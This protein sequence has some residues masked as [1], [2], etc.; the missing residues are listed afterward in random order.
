MVPHPTILGD[1]IIFLVLLLLLFFGWLVLFCLFVCFAS[2]RER[3]AWAV[4]AVH[5]S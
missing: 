2:P 3:K 4:R 5:S 1:E